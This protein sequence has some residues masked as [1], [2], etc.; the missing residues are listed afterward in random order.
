MLGI[1]VALVGIAG[2]CLTARSG[3]RRVASELSNAVT[4][5]GKSIQEGLNNVANSTF[6]SGI[7][8]FVSGIYS[9]RI[10]HNNLS[11]INMHL[12]NLN[13][14]A[15]SAY[16]LYRRE[17]ANPYYVP[18]RANK[19]R[20]KELLYGLM[21][22]WFLYEI[23]FDTRWTVRLVVFNIAMLI[24]SK[25]DT[26]EQYAPNDQEEPQDIPHENPQAAPG[27]SARLTR[28]SQVLLNAFQDIYMSQNLNENLQGSKAGVILVRNED[29]ARNL[30]AYFIHNTEPHLPRKAYHIGQEG[31]AMRY[32][33]RLE[34]YDTV[35]AYL[36]ANAGNE[37]TFTLPR[38]SFCR[39]R[40]L[41]IFGNSRN[42]VRIVNYVEVHRDLQFQL[43]SVRTAA[44]GRVLKVDQLVGISGGIGILVG[45]ALFKFK[46]V[47]LMKVMTCGAYCF[48]PLGALAA[49][50]LTCATV[51]MAG[52]GVCR[53]AK[54][55]N[56]AP[57]HVRYVLSAPPGN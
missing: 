35:F 36:D 44:D 47:C 43:F 29:T 14:L 11:G 16:D 10:L 48:G 31:D 41:C 40:R 54:A 56:A 22:F 4:K 39:S 8:N 19:M 27:P 15:A 57:N 32:L 52:R 42:R 25:D 49:G 53:I 34:N 9:A 2:A 1:L 38:I 17:F 37:H 5:A 13:G 55:N 30:N 45:F 6:V 18:A 24:L 20:G 51:F 12:H 3:G 7:L 28:D 26:D 50:G 46:G 33:Q 21:T 23:D